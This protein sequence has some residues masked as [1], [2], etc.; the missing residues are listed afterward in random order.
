MQVLMLFQFKYDHLNIEES[1]K[2]HLLV[3]FYPGNH[4]N[5]TNIKSICSK[6]KILAASIFLNI[7]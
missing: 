6:K 3:D 4:I 2:F 5:Q 1:V 7:F